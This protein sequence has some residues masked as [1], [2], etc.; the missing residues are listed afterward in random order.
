VN[1]NLWVM[2]RWS[3]DLD[4]WRADIPGL[5]LYATGKTP[6][7]AIEAAHKT[8]AEALPN[9]D[10]GKLLLTREWEREISDVLMSG[11]PVFLHRVDMVMTTNDRMAVAFWVADTKVFWPH[12]LVHE[13]LVD[14]MF[15]S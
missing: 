12:T 2:I 5:E 13:S 11:N 3:D 9:W 6:T 1:Y 8:A 10:L 7:A 14:E 4:C 15:K